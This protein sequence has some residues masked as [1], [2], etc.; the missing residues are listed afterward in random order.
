MPPDL[1]FENAKA[2]LNPG[3]LHGTPSKRVDNSGYHSPVN[4]WFKNIC[5]YFI[6]LIELDSTEH[7]D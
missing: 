7:D 3:G 4:D 6:K 1:L 5:D 2:D